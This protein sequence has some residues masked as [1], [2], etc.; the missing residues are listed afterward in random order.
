[1][2][3]V[4]EILQEGRKARKDS[5]APKAGADGSGGGIHGG[6]NRGDA[7]GGAHGGALD[8][9]NPNENADSICWFCHVDVT[10]LENNKCAGCRKVRHTPKLQML[11]VI[12]TVFRRATV[13]KGA[14]ERTGGGT[15]ITVSRCRRRSRRRK[16]PRRLNRKSVDVARS[17]E[18]GDLIAKPKQS[19]N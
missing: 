5:A 3:K 2:K 11:R 19:A 10:K 14:R 7:H 9:G 12:S 6:G 16:R 8:G 17:K 18:W 15:E 13:T 1:M 4:K